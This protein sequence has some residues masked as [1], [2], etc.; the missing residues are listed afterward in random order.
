MSLEPCPAAKH[1]KAVL[2]LLAWAALQPALVQAES[3][4][5]P[6][7]VVAMQQ[8]VDEIWSL[9]AM[10]IAYKDWQGNVQQDRAGEHPRGHNIA[11]LLVDPLGQPVYWARNDRFA[12]DNGTDH[13]EVRVMRNFLDCPHR[14]QYLGEQ[15]PASYPGARQGK[16]FTLYTTLD[17]CVMCTG[18]MLMNHLTRAVYV[19]SDPD[20]GNVVQRLKSAEKSGWPPYPVTLDIRQADIPEA[21]LLDQAYA[22]LGQKDVIIPFL[23]SPQAERIFAD[24]TERLR[25]FQSEHGQQA[26]VETALR[27]LDEVVDEGFQPDPQ[28]ECPN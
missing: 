2:A 21:K 9:L 12:T 3:Y 11:A 7:A 17:P 20:Y 1:W 10:A 5:D 8:E 19:Q 14:L 26:L 22:K 15:S 13:S 27:Y 28:L 25:G 6:P 16:G 18:M 4:R 23:R 24:A